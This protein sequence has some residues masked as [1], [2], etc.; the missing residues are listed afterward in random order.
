MKDVP[1][2][3]FSA[4]TGAPEAHRPAHPTAPRG[5][6]GPRPS[7]FENRFRPAPSRLDPPPPLLRPPSR[8]EPGHAPSDSWFRLPQPLVPSPVVGFAIGCPEAD[9][10]AHPGAHR[11]AHPGAHR[12]APAFSPLPSESE[13]PARATDEVRS[14]NE[15]RRMASIVNSRRRLRRYSPPDPKRTQERTGARTDPSRRAR[16]PSGR[17]GEARRGRCRTPHR[18]IG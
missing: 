16:R 5:P 1:F 18:A 15:I 13:A 17:A 4:P 3:P 7:P 6:M 14:R 11:P 2:F 10:E 12:L 9:A 8:N